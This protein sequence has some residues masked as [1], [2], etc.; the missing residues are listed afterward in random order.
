MVAFPDIVPGCAGN[1][2]TLTERLRTLLV[3]QLL[4]AATVTDPP[5]AP[6]IKVMLLVVDVPVHPEGLVQTYDVA[7]LTALTE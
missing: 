6:A 4:L 3:P 7:P 5:D 1:A 2:D